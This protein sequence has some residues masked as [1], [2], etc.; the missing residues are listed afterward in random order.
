L[1]NLYGNISTTAYRPGIIRFPGTR[2]TKKGITYRISK[3]EGRK[4]LQSGFL[5]TIPST[6]HRGAFRRK[7]IS[8]L[9]IV[10]AHGPSIWSVI[11]GSPGL[12]TGAQKRAGDKLG[13]NIS[14]QVGVELK[15]W[16]KQ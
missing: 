12:L 6:G 11:T 3:K 9:P 14:D 8:R 16:R 15:R 5:Q 1:R 2:Q 4:L 7:G 10:E 13:K